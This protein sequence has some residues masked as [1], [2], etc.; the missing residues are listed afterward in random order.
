VLLERVQ[1]FAPC[2]LY[3][4]DE[5]SG[6]FICICPG[7]F[8]HDLQ[9][10][11]QAVADRKK[12][13]GKVG[14][15]IKRGFSFFTLSAFAQGFPSLPSRATRDLSGQHSLRTQLVERIKLF[16]PPESADIFNLRAHHR[17]PLCRFQLSQVFRQFGPG[18]CLVIAHGLVVPQ[19]LAG[20][21]MW[22]TRISGF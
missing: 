13:A 17:L 19:F 22:M 5:I 6:R 2:Q 1:Q 3:T 20:C 11:G 16:Y 4:F 15:C 12:I 21:R 7:L 18:I 14:S 8:V 9:R 10:L